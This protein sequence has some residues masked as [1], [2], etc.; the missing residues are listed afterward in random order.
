MKTPSKNQPKAQLQS[1]PKGRPGSNQIVGNGVRR[2]TFLKGLG[3][4]G[5]AFLPGSAILVNHAN[6]IPNDD[7]GGK[8]KKGD[9]A[10]LRFLAAAEI[11]ESDFWEQYWELGGAQP[12]GTIGVPE[13]DFAATNPS[14]GKKPKV[15]GGNPK[16]TAALQL[17]DMDLPQ[18]IL[19]NTDDEFSHANFLLAYLKSKGANTE[20]LQAIEDRINYLTQLKSQEPS[21]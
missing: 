12:T 10:I 15:T 17:L 14:D 19:D 5:A 18:Y 4:T 6:A 16:Y 2:C 7:G 8:L 20:A 11:I 13:D 9:A 21:H 1:P 3:L